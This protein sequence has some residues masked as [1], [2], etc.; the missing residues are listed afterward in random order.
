MSLGL[1]KRPEALFFPRSYLRGR[2][3]LIKVQ[4]LAIKSVAKL[5]RFPVMIGPSACADAFNIL[6]SPPYRQNSMINVSL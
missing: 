2:R 1:R 4:F 5:W 3:W 6:S